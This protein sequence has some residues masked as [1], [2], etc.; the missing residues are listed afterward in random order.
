M[1]SSIHRLL[2]TAVV[3]L[4]AA[5]LGVLGLASA[6]AAPQHLDSAKGPIGWDVYRHLDRF[7]ELPQGVQTKQFSSFDRAGGNGDAGHCLR[8]ATDGSCVLAEA[9]GAG[10]IDSIWE[11][12]DGG[13]PTATGNISVVLDGKT[14]LHAPFQDVVDGKLGAPFVY[15]IVANADQSS[16]GV[17]IIAPMPYRSSMIVYTDHDPIY[18]H[19]T[20]RTFADA[21]GVTTF[22]PTDKASDVITELQNAGTRDPK[23]ALAGAI[24][25]SGHL[26]LQ[27]GKSVQ[28]ATAQGPGTASAVRLQIPQLIAPPAPNNVTDDGRAFGANGYSQFTVKIDPANTGVR[29]TR[30]LDGH[31]GHQRATILVDGQA[32]AEWAPLDIPTGCQWVDQSVDLPAS[33]TAGKS[34]IVVRNQFVS[35]DLDFNEFTYWVDSTVGGQQKRTDTVDV[36]PKH[37]ADESAHAYSIVSQTWQGDGNT[38]CYPPPGGTDQSVL[39]SDDILANARIRVTADGQRTVD[40]PLGEFFGS[41]QADA[42]VKSLMTSMGESLSDWFSAWWPMPYR[43]SLSVSLY[44][45]SQHAITAGNSEVTTAPNPAAA[46]GLSRGTLGYFRATSNQSATTQGQDYVFLH[47]SGHGKFV[48]VTH[49]MQGPTSRGYLEGD[50]RVNVD[51]DRTPQI[52]GTGTEDFYEGGWYFN[53]DTFTNPVNGEPSHQTSANGCPTGSDCTSTYRMMLADSVAFSSGITFGIEHGSVDDVPATYSSTAYWYGQAT[54]T[55]RLTDTIDVG[56]AASEQ[57][58]S[59]TSSDP[60]AR[61]T[62]TATY[63]GND[64][65]PQPLTEDLRATQAPVSFRVTTD[66]DNQGVVL[67][68]TSDQTQGGQQATVLVDGKPVGTWLEPLSN[69]Q[70]SLAGRHVP[71]SGRG[72]GR[73]V[74]R[75]DHV[76]AGVGCAGVERG[77]VHRAVIGRAVHRPE[78]AVEGHRAQCDIGADQCRVIDVDAGDRRRRSRPLRRVRLA[79]LAGGDR[80]EHPCRVDGRNRRSPT[81]AWACAR[82]GTTALSPWTRRAIAVR[83][84]ARRPAPPATRLVSRPNRCCR[85]SRRPRR[86]TRRATA[87]ASRGRATPSSGSTRPAATT[88]S[89]SRSTS[90]RRARTT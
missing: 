32:V 63:E 16:G 19:V 30:R 78:R 36:G 56:N 89:R 1:R 23:P 49:S 3:A 15:P 83:R 40:A 90:R 24:T 9:K 43:S 11:T 5:A 70:Q 21:D 57:A 81:P 65:A 41:K 12:R 47:A 20:Y 52:H 35:S 6:Q 10:E 80:L 27:P 75:H 8:T 46:Q 33:A 74:T 73:S 14:V 67:S 87:A 72:N 51:G 48:G 62:L 88:T 4:L 53:R 2:R 85:R 34:S 18:Y 76:A 7:A 84:R 39:A 61:T 58:H 59:Y 69:N 64:S 50:E 37:A 54:D 31:I 29:L 22:D 44:N 55:E 28:L 45:G 79:D 77:G 71:R 60:G 25:Q 42:T 86:W 38:A 82:P 68:R 13:D 26:S 17:Y 66:D